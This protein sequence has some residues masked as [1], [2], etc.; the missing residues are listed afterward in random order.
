MPSLRIGAYVRRHK[1]D[2]WLENIQFLKTELRWSRVAIIFVAASLEIDLPF[3][4]WRFRRVHENG[5][6]E[7]AGWGAL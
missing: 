1:A 4:G 6:R 3:P 2:R 5:K 7:D